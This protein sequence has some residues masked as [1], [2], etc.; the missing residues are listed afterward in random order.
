MTSMTHDAWSAVVDRLVA[1]H[2]ELGMALAHARIEVREYPAGRV[3][4]LRV[5]DEVAQVLRDSRES[6]A[7]AIIAACERAGLTIDDVAFVE[8]ETA[9]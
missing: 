6:Y 5:H 4:V 3:L 9:G 7:P 2:L 8:A 1:D